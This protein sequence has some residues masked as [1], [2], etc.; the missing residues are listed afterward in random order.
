MNGAGNGKLAAPSTRVLLSKTIVA[1]AVAE[2]SLPIDPG[3]LTVVMIGPVPVQRASTETVCNPPRL[4]GW[5]P[6]AAPAS[7][8]LSVSTIRRPSA[9]VE[10]S[11]HWNEVDQRAEATCSVKPFPADATAGTASNARAASSE[12]TYL[13]GR[14]GRWADRPRGNRRARMGDSFLMVRAVGHSQPAD[15]YNQEG[16]REIHDRARWAV[17]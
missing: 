7:M 15:S 10:P 12:T 2:R 5:G 1:V 4:G 14:E 3:P 11:G 16:L 9:A 17:T 8:K 6:G 13:Y